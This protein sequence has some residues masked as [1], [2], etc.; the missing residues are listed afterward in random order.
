M[1]ESSIE[2]LRRELDA[3]AGGVTRGADVAGLA[4]WAA[5]DAAPLWSA[6]F[7]ASFILRTRKLMAKGSADR[8]AAEKLSLAVREE[9]G[10]LGALLRSIA[11]RAP[12][13]ERIAFEQTFLATTPDALARFFELCGG[14]S[15]IQHWRLDHRAD[16]A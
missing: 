15:W 3:A 12:E 16:L 9:I 7:K 6:A 11:A 1:H 8:E 2:L 10:A 14:L 4:R 13:P 5:A